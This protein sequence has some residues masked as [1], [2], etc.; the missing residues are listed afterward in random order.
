MFEAIAY[1]A[2]AAA[3]AQ[4]VNPILNFLPL[5]IL[6]FIFYFF[7]IK[8]QQKKQ[9]ETQTMIQ[10]LK[11]GD[12]IYTVGGILG[13]ITSIQNDYVVIKTGDSDT[14]ME[15]LKSGIA[16]VRSREEQKA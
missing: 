3:P 4:E 14:K 2:P 11:K 10:N 1:A 13:T 16:G 6:I 9:R 5:I 7:L 15:I 8:P 12:R